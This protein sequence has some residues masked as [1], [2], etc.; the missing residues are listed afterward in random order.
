MSDP[1][2]AWRDAGLAAA[3]LAIDPVGLGGVALRARHGPARDA[4]LAAFTDML[5]AGVPCRRLPPTADDHRLL[6]G[7]DLT[8]TLATGRPLAA[9]GLLAETDGGVLVLPMAER[10]LPG[11]VARLAS[12]LDT[13]T[14]H[15]ERDGLSLRAPARLGLVAL[16][17]GAEPED[18]LDGA[19]ADRLAF[20]V[21][22]SHV[23]ARPEPVPFA[24]AD[25][26]AA[27]AT[28]AGV[29]LGEDAAAA[30]AGAATAFGIGSLR[31]PIFA[32]RAARAVHALFGARLTAQA[33][34]ELAARLV[35]APRATRLPAEP[36]SE[37]EQPPDA[38][39]PPE[40][41]EGPDDAPTAG[42]QEALADQ[43]LEA[44]R[45]A[46]PPDLL[47]SL[48]GRT[49]PRA[50]APLGRAGA[51]R[52][53]PD[54]GRPLGSRPGRIGRGRL[55]IVA[56]LTAAPPWQPLRRRQAG[57][58][59]PA[60]A[61][62]PE[63]I[64][65]KVLKRHSATASIFVVDASGSAAVARLA[66]AKGAVEFLLAEAYVRRDQVALVAFRGATA[67]LLLPPT[68]APALAKKRLAALPGGGGTPLAAGLA[69]G[70]SLAEKLAGGGVVPQL[71][72][73]TDGRANIDLAGQPGRGRA[74]ED[75]EEIAKA[76]RRAGLSALV[77]DVGARPRTEARQ[78]AE[79]LGA[80]YLPLP[81]AD[82]ALISQAAKMGPGP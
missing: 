62:R 77:I 55:D 6:G 47:A 81:K 76:C 23:P 78:L 44:V 18:R 65:V 48:A 37:P 39:P 40:E 14:V 32:L 20:A 38:P 24:R 30:L 80:R 28:L 50:D 36:E 34:L 49:A 41:N 27:R 16:D 46:L 73:L 69:A 52:R 12:A 82:A 59:A 3:L 70:L 67:E 10:A 43:V 25:V 26:V 74:A 8:A 61:I 29:D 11:L 75:A 42:P 45:A 57:L 54:R 1:A 31:A 64:R 63:D 13:G 17:E 53:A 56:P 15:T 66:E 68:A 60:L 5:P 9:K 7:L 2:Q 72:V 35:L 79:V 19:L 4:W 71:L 51:E 33:A 22:L 58:S 21:D